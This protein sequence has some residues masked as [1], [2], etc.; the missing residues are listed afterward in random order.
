MLASQNKT[1]TISFRLS[2]KLLHDLKSEARG[3]HVSVNTLVNQVL[4]RYTEWG[5]HAGKFGF[6]PIARPFIK[7]VNDPD[8]VNVASREGKQIAKDIVLFI[9]GTYDKESVIN[10]MEAWLNSTMP[11]K[12]EVID[13]RHEFVI[14][15]NLGQGWSSYLKNI[16]EEVFHD[17]GETQME[18][19]VTPSALLFKCSI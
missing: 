4:A 6:I 14:Q 3:R 17:V 12:H 18:F 9:E 5:R 19:Q 2:E 1:K 10:F 13:N 7:A 15:H 11:H 16:L 8:I